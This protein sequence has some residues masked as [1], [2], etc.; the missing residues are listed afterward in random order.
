MPRTPPTAFTAISIR[1]PPSARPWERS[2]SSRFCARSV[3]EAVSYTLPNKRKLLDGIDLTLS[4]GEVI[5]VVSPSIRSR[6]GRLA[7]LLAA[8]HRAAIGPDSLRRRRHRL[9]HARIAA[10]RN[11]LRRRQRSVLHRHCRREHHLQPFRLHAFRRDR[12]GQDGPRAQFHPEAAAGL[13]NGDR[14]ARRAIGRR[15]GIPARAG[16]GRVCGIRR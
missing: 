8:V 10:G 4:A 15:A 7:C 2:S 3:F 6:R 1:F 5:A 11:G 9:G 12:S 14:R 13:R 16:P